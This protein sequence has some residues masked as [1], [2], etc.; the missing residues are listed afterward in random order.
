GLAAGGPFLPHRAD[1]LVV[2]GSDAA[3]NA[4]PLLR[5]DLAHA[6]AL[7][8]VAVRTVALQPCARHLD[9]ERDVVGVSGDRRSV[10]SIRA[11]RLGGSERL[12]DRE[13]AGLPVV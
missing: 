5:V 2:L 4:V 1:E 11:R 10:R 6:P 9:M 12:H 3:A 8:P 7:R 13:E